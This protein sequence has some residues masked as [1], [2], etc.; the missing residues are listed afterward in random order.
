MSVSKALKLAGETGFYVFPVSSKKVPFTANGFLDAANDPETIKELWAGRPDALV[1]VAT[2]LSGIVVLDLD[3]KERD[4]K[5]IDGFASLGKEWLEVPESF[6]YYSLSGKGRHVIYKAPEGESLNGVTN[7]RKMPGVDRRAGGSY[8]VWASDEVP[9]VSK[10]AE[11]PEWLCDEASL[12][13]L[14]TFEGGLKD[15]YEELTPGKPNALVRRAIDRIPEDMGHGEMVA[16]QHEAVRLGAEGNPGVPELLE[17]LEEAFLNRDPAYHTTPVEEWAYKFTEALSSGV[18][19]FGALTERVV[20]L[21]EYSLSLVPDSVSDAEVNGDPLTKPSFSRLLNTLAR[22]V[23][24]PDTIASILWNAPAPKDLAREWGI[25]FLY[26]RI[27]EAVTKPAPEQENPAYEEQRAVEVRDT[28]LLTDEEQAIIA[29]TPT[30]EDEYLLFAQDDGFA[31]DK[32]SRAGSWAVLSMAFAF[33]AFIPVSSTNK[34]GLNLWTMVLGESGTGKSVSIMFRDQVLDAMF[35]GSSVGDDDNSDKPGYNLGADSSLAGLHEALILRD[36]EPSFFGTDEAS[37]FFKE[38]SQNGTWKTGVEDSL[39]NW[40]NGRVDPSNKV[41]LKELRGKSALTSLTTQFYATPD[42]LLGAL[43]RD[44]FFSGFLARFQWVVGDP[45]T[46]DPSRFQLQEQVNIEDYDQDPKAIK[47]IAS[48][49]LYMSL[50]NGPKTKPVLSTDEARNRMSEA[51][52]KLYTIGKGR[53]NWDIVQPALVRY[54]EAMRKVAAL[55]AL[56]RGSDLVELPDALRAI[57]TISEW[58]DNLYVVVD[59]IGQGEFQNDIKAIEDWIRERGGA[60]TSTRLFHKF[61]NM[62]KKDPRELDVRIEFLLRSGVLVRVDKDGRTE[63][64]LNE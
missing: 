13:T 47:E 20:N 9:D 39:A 41:R 27:E 22:D 53:A 24:D 55:N 43:S 48:H 8:V 19:K 6:G 25:E 31:N 7:Y 58:F 32:Y 33:R 2:G 15:W 35:G 40:Y 18:Q 14:H 42:R 46:E 5:V 54:V 34:M 4:G 26:T 60:V 36:R 56:H 61:K 49:F 17:A 52:Q 11:A 30:F 51:Y 64:K 21:P 44:Q 45:P 59:R 63:Y 57:A 62:V 16:A 38:I 37:G 29:W 10:F 3:Y 50:R 12:R 28:D 23:A 1:G